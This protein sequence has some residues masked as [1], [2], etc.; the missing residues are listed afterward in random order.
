VSDNADRDSLAY[1]EMRLILARIIFEFDLRLADESKDWLRNASAFTTW[2]KMPLYV[3][4]TP[5]GRG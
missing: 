5:V 4:L 2:R 1:A 3:Y